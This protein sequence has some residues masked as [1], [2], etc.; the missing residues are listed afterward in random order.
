MNEVIVHFSARQRSVLL[1][2]VPEYSQLWSALQNAFQPRV[3]PIQQTDYIVI[4]DV[5]GAEMLLHVA[6][7]HC[8]DAVK[9]IELA[10]ADSRS[11]S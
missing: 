1:A 8:P 10:I 3:V 9:N 6:R 5:P 2:A 4:C 7:E 11:L